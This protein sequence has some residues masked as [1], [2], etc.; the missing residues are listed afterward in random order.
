MPGAVTFTRRLLHMAGAEDGG[1]AEKAAGGI[2]IS[3]LTFLILAASLLLFGALFFITFQ[4]ER[5]YSLTVKATDDYISWEKNGALITA[6]SDYLTEQARLYTQTLNKEFADNYFEELH[7]TQRRE[8]ALETLSEKD[9]GGQ[10][11]L[12]LKQALERSDAL[13]E[14]EL[15]AIKL[16]ALASGANLAA[17][18][19][20][21]RTLPVRPADR[22]LGPRAKLILA[23]DVVFNAQYQD[24]KKTIMDDITRYLN[25][26]IA[27]TQKMQ[28]YEEE[29]LGVLL[30]RGR[31]VLGLL[32]LLS[33]ATAAA[34]VLLVLRPLRSYVE[35]IRQE[36]MFAPCGSREFR[37]LAKAYNEFFAIKVHNDKVL[38]YKA[39]HDPLTGLA[40]RRTYDAVRETLKDRLT[41]VG[42]LLI[43]VDRFKE[44]NDGYGHETGD[45]VLCRVANMLERSFRS[46]D[47]C[48]R[49]GGDEFAVIMKDAAQGM[50]EIIRKKI[51]A[52][53]YKLQN[54]EGAT[55]PVS[56][57]VGGAFSRA[58]FTDTLY[59]EA[60]K[61]LYAVK[62]KGRH[63]VAFY[64]D[65]V[66]GEE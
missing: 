25:G 35:S 53:N 13:T 63:G 22:A 45:R 64:G 41:P 24:E 37:L 1:N 56:L 36:R 31:L 14:R 4:L 38:R 43:D 42:L 15:Y 16:A 9:V 27:Q 8:K 60:D 29:R 17:F 18:P 47:F 50:K 2:R 6:G 26:I 66:A 51:A 59:G 12:S 11:Y 40:N 33:L 20:E 7:V 54:P 44:I 39:E 19:T 5:T 23:R 32:F 65:D 48:V 30:E 28:S 3:W 52:I 10:R 57:S 21:I 55:P 49:F 61:A 62:S 58:G 34:L 46:G